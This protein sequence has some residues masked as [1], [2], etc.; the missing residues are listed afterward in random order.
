[1][2]GA[3]P[4]EKYVRSFSSRARTKK[5]EPQRPKKDWFLFYAG[6]SMS[7]CSSFE[8]Q[9]QKTLD[10]AERFWYHIVNN[11]G[12]STVSENDSEVKCYVLLLEK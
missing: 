11:K 1:M 7:S 9:W 8:K 4:Y 10:I 12:K 5:K 3:S 2:V 6:I